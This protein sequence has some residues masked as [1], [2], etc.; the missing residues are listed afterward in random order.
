MILIVCVDDRGGMMF[1]HRRQ[2]RDKALIGDVCRMTEGR[3]LW[4]TAY[5]APLFAECAGETA[6]DEA[7][8]WKAAEGDYCFAEEGLPDG[9]EAHAEELVVYR[10]NR[11]YPADVHF[12]TDMTGWTLLSVEEFAGSSHERITR[13]IYRKRRKEEEHE[14]EKS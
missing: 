11:S 8:L 7:F 5:T 9:W 12:E 3:K 13:E 14:N 2:S 6:V 1:N 4:M 10:W